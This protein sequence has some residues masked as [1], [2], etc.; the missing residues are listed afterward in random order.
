MSLTQRLMRILPRA[1]LPIAFLAP[2]A[3]AAALIP[4]R[5]HTDTANIAL[6]LMVVV[7]GVALF[8]QRTAT[9]ISAISAAIWFDF[10]QTRPYY[11]FTISTHDDVVTAVLLLLVGIVVGEL[12]IRMRRNLV[13]AQTGSS[14]IGQLHRIA[15]LV[16]GGTPPEKVAS[17]VS[18]LLT[19]LFQLRGCSFEPAPFEHIVKIA[20]FERSGNI[21]FG[22]LYWGV[23]TM[24][25]PGKQVE[26]EVSGYG[27][28]FG[29][30]LLE[31]TPGEPIGF[32][33]C[34]I[35]IAL[36]DQVAAA[37]MSTLTTAPSISGTPAPT[38]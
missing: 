36:A 33:R 16:A 31:P 17:D 11:S 32:D 14:D 25:F 19:Y 20:R 8:G 29:R 27:K 2:P 3:V 35:A 18:S 30:F 23:G 28:T 1:A 6:C 24:G 34:I 21:V 7:V 13:A 10:F 38:A 15:E 4:A 37:Y 5:T 22:E 12:V 9:V 26:L